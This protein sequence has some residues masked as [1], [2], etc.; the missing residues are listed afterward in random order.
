MKLHHILGAAMMLA[1]SAMPLSAENFEYTFGDFDDES[2]DYI[3]GSSW[4]GAPFCFTYQST[5]SQFIYTPTDLGDMSNG[6]VAIYKI[7]FR[8]FDDGGVCDTVYGT[9]HAAI[10]NCD[11]LQYDKNDDGSYSF[12]EYDETSAATAMLEQTSYYDGIP[13]EVEFSFENPLIYNG[14]GL[15]VTAYCDDVSTDMSSSNISFFGTSMSTGSDVR[16]LSSVSDRSTWEERYDNGSSGS[17]DYTDYY[18]AVPQ[19]RIYYTDDVDA[20][21]ATVN[22]DNTAAPAEYYNLQGIKVQNPTHGIYIRQSNGHSQ[23]VVL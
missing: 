14:A 17:S 7:A 8:F 9:L 20:G 19:I 6:N 13:F 4:V 3:S 5:A 2:P 23:K 10:N 11:E 16:T 15:L 21:V 18:K 12:L 22:K 1:A